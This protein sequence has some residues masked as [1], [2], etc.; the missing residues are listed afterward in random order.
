[1]PEGKPVENRERG[2]LSLILSIQLITGMCLGVASQ[3]ILLP[4]WIFGYV[5]PGL[6]FGVFKLAQTIEAFNLP[7]RIWP[8]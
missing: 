1:M 2:G 6:G 7:G 5:L 3:F 8:I 4:W